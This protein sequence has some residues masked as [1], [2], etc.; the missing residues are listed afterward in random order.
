MYLRSIEP[1]AEQISSS[2]FLS[3]TAAIFFN[4]K[5]KWTKQKIVI[6]RILRC[7][8]LEPGFNLTDL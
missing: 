5:K 2:K 8:F 3:E 7:C 1:E 4:Q 6:K